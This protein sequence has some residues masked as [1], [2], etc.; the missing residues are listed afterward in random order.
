MMN[1]EA[2]RKA[3]HVIAQGYKTG[4][5]RP[6]FVMLA[7][8]CVWSSQWRFDRLEGRDAVINYFR[9]KGKTLREPGDGMSV[10]VAELTGHH[11]KPGDPVPSFFREGRPCV[12]LSQVID[13]E[14]VGTLAIPHCNEEGLI[15]RIDMALP[16]VFHLRAWEENGS[17]A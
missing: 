2:E 6:L 3:A 5:F 12:L 8:D 7:E 11:L 15:E 1:P 10:S 17:G 9:S 16:A 4:D 13:G 14:E